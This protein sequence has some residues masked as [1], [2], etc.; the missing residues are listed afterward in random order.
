MNF[1]GTLQTENMS[2]VWVNLLLFFEQ[3][4]FGKKLSLSKKNRT[5]GN[6]FHFMCP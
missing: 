4:I 6:M 5:I 2:L 1:M 3:P